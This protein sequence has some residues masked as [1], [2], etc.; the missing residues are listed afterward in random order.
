MKQQGAL[1]LFV[2]TACLAVGLPCAAQTLA[3][4]IS[5]EPVYKVAIQR[6]FHFLE[7]HDESAPMMDVYSP[8]DNAAS[9]RCG[10]VLLHGNGGDRK[11]LAG[12]ATIFAKQGFVCFCPDYQN[13][14]A[15]LEDCI[16]GAVKWA[17]LNAETFGIAV[18]RIAVFGTSYG[19]SH[20]ISLATAGHFPKEAR[21]AAAVAA[22]GGVFYPEDCDADDA[23]VLYF[24]GRE[25]FNFE[26]PDTRVPKLKAGGVRYGWFPIDGAGHG[27]A[28][29]VIAGFDL[30][31]REITTE[32]L[33]ICLLGPRLSRMALIHVTQ[34]GPGEVNLDP[35]NGFYPRGTEVLIEAKPAE[36]NVLVR[37]E[38]DL[39][40]SENPVRV[41]VERNM[42]VKA[43]FR[44][45]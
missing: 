10:L 9:D 39:N 29:D 4:G 27:L 7:G 2:V 3:A 31:L 40:G 37:W 42:K 34:E 6:D 20:A 13:T 11:S 8:A 24:R 17:R 32:F 33:I 30:T 35:I 25:D 22:P 36:D 41:K 26:D 12:F 28:P 43:V 19:G 14:S 23:P 18:E 38:G 45:R 1:R 44:D 16:G 5:R 21:V 15:D